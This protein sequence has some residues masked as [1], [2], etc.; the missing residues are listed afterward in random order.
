MEKKYDIF[1]LFIGQKTQDWLVKATR[2]IE[3]YTKPMRCFK[4]FL[5]VKL[6]LGTDDVRIMKDGQGRILMQVQDFDV[7]VMTKEAFVE[8]VSKPSTLYFNEDFTEVHCSC[9]MYLKLRDLVQERFGESLTRKRQA[10]KPVVEETPFD[11]A[12]KDA[13]EDALKEI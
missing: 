6:Y 3:G 11:E 5:N 12:M 10:A 8:K 4:H 7:E 9:E 2:P 1:K 13:L